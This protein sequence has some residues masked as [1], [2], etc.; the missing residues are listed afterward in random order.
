MKIK[1]I[2][3]ESLLFALFII[4]MSIAA[5]AN[6]LLYISLSLLVV[7]FIYINFNKVH[8]SSIII[9]KI[10]ITLLLFQNF[11]IGI[12]AHYGG[13]FSSSL[14]FI[15]QVPTIFIVI[16]YTAIILNS[17]IKKLD[18]IFLIYAGLCLV[19]SFVGN[20][21]ITARITYLRNFLIFYMAFSIGKYYLN[22]KTKVD[23]F[24]RFFLQLSIIA[25][26]FGTIGIILGKTFYQAMGV[27]EVYKAKQY[28]AYR[29]GLPGNFM[30]IFFGIWVN[31]FASLYYD[32]V[33]FSYFMALS[34]LVAYIS[35]KNALFII[36]CLCEILTFG[37]GG[38]LILCLT[39]VCIITQRLFS[40]YNA[41][42]IRMLIIVCAIFGII[43]LVYIIQ[44]HFSDDF[45]TYNHFYGMMTGL[46]AVKKNPLGHGLGTAGN[47]IKTAETSR[48]EISETGLIN[49]A[50][51]IGVMG[52]TLFCYIFLSTAKGAF[53]QFKITK[54]KVCL[55]CSFLSIVLLIVSIYQENTYTPQCIVPY[56]LLIGGAANYGLQTVRGQ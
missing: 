53:K 49:M 4:M 43:V 17:S 12:G 1:I 50:Y 55:M 27:L 18:I 19:F 44:T 56:M 8:S 51:Q 14:S 23:E 28:M 10:A 9:P 40:K 42:I 35:K 46:D 15:T 13:N 34:C 31:R 16:S 38:I 22:S 6:I 7:V 2:K 54:E 37:K 25:V 52:T 21:N 45:G 3:K 24:I 33:N 20:G 11:S 48:Q 39:L 30:T 26:L 36:F 47:L 32:P 41:K 29:D 5:F